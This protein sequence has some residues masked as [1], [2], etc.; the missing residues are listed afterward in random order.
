MPVQVDEYGLTPK[1]RLFCVHYIENKGHG[2]NAAI[3]A[4]YSKSTAYSIASENLTKPEIKRYLGKFMKEAAEKLC[5][6]PEYLLG[7]LKT[8]IDRS[9]PEFPDY[10]DEDTKQ[11]HEPELISKT[12]ARAAVA[13]IAEINRMLGNHAPEKTDTRHKL[14][15]LEDLISD[16]RSREDSN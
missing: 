8:G 5:I 10:V 12:D 2:T 4:G 16:C 11:R 9:I 13:C 1:Q 6:T 14:E 3:A 15:G 7:K